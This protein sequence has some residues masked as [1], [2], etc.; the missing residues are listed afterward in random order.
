MPVSRIDVAQHVKDPAQGLPA[1][2]NGNALAGIGH[3]HAP[4]QAVRGAHGDAAHRIV[5]DV[6][7]HFHRQRMITDRQRQRV[8]D[9]R[10]LSFPEVD[11]HHGSHDLGYDTRIHLIQCR[12]LL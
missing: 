9:R 11:V 12:Y 2:R 4:L 6:L 10:Q 8:I 3:G 1:H 7:G 5:A